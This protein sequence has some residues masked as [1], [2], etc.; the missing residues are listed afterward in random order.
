MVFSVRG[1]AGP[2]GSGAAY[3]FHAA[4]FVVHV[5]VLG[6][7]EH[8]VSLGDGQVDAVVFVRTDNVEVFPL[9]T[10]AVSF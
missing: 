6:E 1:A 9:Y 2:K 4:G 7:L 8:D 5:K 3:D 10:L